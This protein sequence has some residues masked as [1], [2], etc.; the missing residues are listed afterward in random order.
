MPSVLQLIS[1]SA[2]TDSIST[3]GGDIENFSL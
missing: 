1:V 2:T 3:S